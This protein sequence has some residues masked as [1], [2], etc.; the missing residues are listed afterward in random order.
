MNEMNRSLTAM[1]R[2][3]L[4][5]R[6]EMALAAGVT[7]E[8]ELHAARDYLFPEWQP[9]VRLT[10]DQVLAVTNFVLGEDNVLTPT[11]V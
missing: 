9:G 6:V 10:D 11:P 1:T 8:G 3:Q 7:S 5:S 4:I 2:D